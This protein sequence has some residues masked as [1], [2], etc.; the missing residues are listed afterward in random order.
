MVMDRAPR[1]IVELL[2]T[3]HF[4]EWTE[5]EHVLITYW[6]AEDVRN[7][8]V[9]NAILR[10]KNVA[11]DLELFASFDK[12]QAWA[13]HASLMSQVQD[14]SVRSITFNWKVLGYVAA[15]IAVVLGA[16]LF[17]VRTDTVVQDRPIAAIQPGANEA[18]LRLADGTVV[19]LRSDQEGLLIGEELTYEDGKKVLATLNL[20]VSSFEINTPRGGQYRMTLPDGSKVWLNAETKLAYHED[21]NERNIYLDG[22]AYFEVKRKYKAASNTLKPF[23]VHIDQQKISVLGTHFNVKSY[24]VDRKSYTTLLEGSVRVDSDKQN[25]TLAP[26]EQAVLQQ[27]KLAKRTVDVSTVMAWKEGDFVFYAERLD[28]I[29]RQVGR[30]YDV[31]FTIESERLQAERFE[32]MVPRFAQLEELLDL[33]Q[34]TGKLKFSYKDRMINVIEK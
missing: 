16:V 13:K 22:E 11:S 28:E 5:Q 3:V 31:D 30:W 15:S 33:L 20:S 10:Q 1:H 4:S 25:Q 26:G 32:I 34:R 21:A 29:L 2:A 18:T 14:T 17:S 27:K 6:L 7:Q 12:E 9:Y 24:K 8:E 23:Q 19:P